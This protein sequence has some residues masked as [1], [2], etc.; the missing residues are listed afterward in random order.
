MA[1]SDSTVMAQNE[2]SCGACDNTAA[3]RGSASARA[4]SAKGPW[5]MTNVTNTPTARKAISLTIDS[6]AIAS[7]KPS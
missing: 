5:N 1:N 6:A 3:V 4:N 7:I 2:A